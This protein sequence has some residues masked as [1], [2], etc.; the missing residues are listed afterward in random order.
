MGRCRHSPCCMQWRGDDSS[1]NLLMAGLSSGECS[2]GGFHPWS[3]PPPLLEAATATKGV[4]S[5]GET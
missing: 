2:H 4:G 5:W 3:R 1:L